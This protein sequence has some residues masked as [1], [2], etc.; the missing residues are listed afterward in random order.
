MISPELHLIAA[1]LEGLEE[2]IITKL[3]DRAQFKANLVIYKA[4]QSGFDGAENESLFDLRIRYQEEMDAYFGR[5]CVPEE[6][7]FTLNLP[8]PRRKVNLPPSCL[9]IDEYERVNLTAEIKSAYFDMVPRF[10]AEGDDGQYGSSVEHD[11][12]ALQAIG[13]R[14]HFGAMY[15]AESKY[16]SDT[17]R[18]RQLIRENNTDTLMEL[19]TRKEVEERILQRVKVKVNHIQAEVN[20]EIRITIDPGVVFQFY[21]DHVIPLT[22][23]GEVLYLLNRRTDEK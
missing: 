1:Q 17:D 4:G 23:K 13:R 6:R 7:P 18:Y 11:V 19:L 2:T 3:I 9:A 16:L 22:K 15:V 10:C 5:F 8:S 12:Y 14:I 21:R 20:P